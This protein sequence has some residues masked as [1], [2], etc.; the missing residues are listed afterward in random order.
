MR[1]RH[2][3]VQMAPVSLLSLAACLAAAPDLAAAAPA[4]AAAGSH[5]TGGAP[6]ATLLSTP[7]EAA[8]SAADPVPIP[9]DKVLSFAAQQLKATR[10]AFPP[11][12]A[13]PGRAT[14]PDGSWPEV[15]RTDW[16]AGFYPGWLWQ[17]HALTNK[18]EWSK[19]ATK[20]LPGLEE[21][22]YDTGSHD[23]GFIMLS[24]YGPAYRRVAPTST[25]GKRY[26][27]ILLAQRYSPRLGMFRSWGKDLKR[28]EFQ[29]VIDNMMNLELMWVA[30]R[31]PGGKTSWRDMAR[32]HA[33]ATAA[34]FF[35]PDSST[36]H[37]LEFSLKSR[38]VTF[39]GTRQGYSNS[40]TWDA[41]WAI[42]GFTQAYE[43]TNKT[44]FRR[45][46]GKAAE[47]FLKRL[48]PDWVPFYWDFDAPANMPYKDTSAGAV[49]ADG[50]LRLS[51]WAKGEAQGR[52]RSAALRMLSALAT[53]YLSSSAPAPQP[54]SV[55]RNGTGAVFRGDW[56][57][58]TSYGD[59]YFLEA[60][61]VGRSMK[62]L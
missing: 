46:A 20:L 44:E 9:L 57:T 32:S 59:Y 22:Q 24:S 16:V 31:L 3:L 28:D 27:S 53:G 8:I 25:L 33:R 36:Y 62:L 35:R 1:A 55:L 42:Y 52:Y 17:M 7:T 6:N 48:T 49:A 37:K 10:K 11:G 13:F 18:S 30:S 15:D 40:S 23:I 14:L 4:T 56:G 45:V 34:H 61:A 19:A 26:R 51:R 54:A 38:K 5:G 12:D 58:G 50:L 41:A 21:T 43:A 39:R 60:L 29:V 2:R 47:L